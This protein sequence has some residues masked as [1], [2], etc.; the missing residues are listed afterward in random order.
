MPY[1]LDANPLITAKNDAFRFNVCPGFWDWIEQKHNE[2]QVFS[3]D[4]IQAELAAIADQLAVWANDRPASFFLP[5]G[6]EIQ[7]YIGALA[8]WAN[9]GNF[10]PAAVAEFMVSADLY[11]IAHARHLGYT[12]VTLE[13][14]DPGCRRRVKIP[15]ACQ[16]IG[17]TCVS[18]Y[19]ML[20]N[21]GARF[22]LAPPLPEVQAPAT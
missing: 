16:H 8:T 12:L 10:L 6:P 2:G 4:R 14:P 21:E 19:E 17:V 9:R 5:S 3:I 13:T 20:E 18:P 22:I 1:L 11:L 7:G 15:D